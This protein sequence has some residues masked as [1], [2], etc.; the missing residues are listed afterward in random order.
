MGKGAI[1]LSIIPYVDWHSCLTFLK[2]G[3]FILTIVLSV[4]ENKKP[5]HPRNSIAI[6]EQKNKTIQDN[7]SSLRI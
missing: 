6:N 2:E 3:M 5:T 1:H 4:T 7:S